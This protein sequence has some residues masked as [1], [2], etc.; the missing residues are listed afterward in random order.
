ME[1]AKDL[2]RALKNQIGDDR[3]DLWFSDV[4]IF[5]KDQTVH[6]CTATAFQ[7]ERVRKNFQ[8][9]ITGAAGEVGLTES[10][11]LDFHV[12]SDSDKFAQ[13]LEVARS[14]D[15]V[16]RAPT[17]QDVA[18]P[19]DH[20]DKKV[21]PADTTDAV[22]SSSTAARPASPNASSPRLRAS[23]S[24][25]RGRRF[26][27]MSTFVKGECNHIACTS[28]EM[29]AKQPGDITPLVIHGST[30]VG[31]SHLVEA[32]WCEAKKRSPRSRVLYLSAEQ[33]TTYFLDAL[34]GGNG[35]PAFRRKYRQADI[36][37]ID[38][39]QFFIGKQATLVELAYTIDFDGSVHPDGR[40]S[41][42][43]A[44]ETGPRDRQSTVW[45]LGL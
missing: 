26:Q 39:I 5:A 10:V 44:F 31:K 16:D 18:A 21:D 38:D 4:A 36:L 9:A 11:R 30:G 41:A 22:S 20:A 27:T 28:V 32:I 17:S 1:F 35:L 14:G 23:S 13:L 15:S 25:T 42:S 43:S 7:L 24:A 6:V 40:P 33:Y 19:D 45:W 34:R 12:E 29:V 37:I 8:A 3:F 2:R